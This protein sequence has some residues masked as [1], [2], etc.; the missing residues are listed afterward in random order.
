TASLQKRIAAEVDA[1]Y[2]VLGAERRLF[3][4]CEKVAHVAIEHEPADAAH[5]HELLCNE[6]RGIEQ[7][8]RQPRRGLLVD[9]LHAEL[10][11]GEVPSLDRLPEIAT[12]IV[13]IH[14]AD[15]L[16]LRPQQRLEAEL[17]LPVELHERRES[18]RPYEAKRVNPEP[19]H[20]A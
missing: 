1:R 10:P 13:R 11:L 3:G 18:L 6:L 7:V 4:F 15:P 17:R 20:E 16:G 5:R 12:V 9:E 2:D 19:F 14:S 8:E